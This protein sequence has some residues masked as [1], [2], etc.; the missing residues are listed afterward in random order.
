MYHFEMHN[1]QKSMCLVS[2]LY[3]LIYHLYVW[4]FQIQFVFKKN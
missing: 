1:I 2:L 3:L 4:T